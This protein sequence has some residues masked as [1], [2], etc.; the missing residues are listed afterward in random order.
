MA[1]WYSALS[2]R[3][4]AVTGACT[5]LGTELLR[6]LEEDARISRVLALDVR[7]PSIRGTKIEYI[8]LDLTQPTVDGE[9]ATLLQR[10]QVD[11][12]VHGAFLSFPTH[13]RSWGSSS[14]LAPAPAT[15]MALAN[16][17]VSRAIRPDGAA[18]RLVATAPVSDG[19][20]SATWSRDRPSPFRAAPRRSAHCR[21]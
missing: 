5:F 18:Q 7:Q 10:H 6:R 20:L 4:V 21:A 11:T 9:L 15:P 14:G 17:C 12:F 8:N 3:V 19:V 13:A 2:C 16:A 1:D